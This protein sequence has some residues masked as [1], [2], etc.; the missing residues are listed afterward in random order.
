MSQFSSLEDYPNFDTV[1]KTEE[2][3]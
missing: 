1:M 2:A 3:E